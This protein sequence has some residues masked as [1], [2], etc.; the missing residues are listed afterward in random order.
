MFEDLIPELQGP[1]RDLYEASGAAGLI[2]RVTSTL[3]TAR[4]QRRLRRRWESG[5]SQFPAALPGTSAHEFGYAFDMVVA[6]FEAL[7]DV[8]YTWQ[9]WGGIWGGAGDPVHFEYPGFTRPSPEGPSEL[10]KAV[11]SALSP[12]PWW[13]GL[14]GMPSYAEILKY[15]TRLEKRAGADAAI[16]WLWGVF[17]T[18][19]P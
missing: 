1:A 8:G 14:L 5:L 3:R 2:P 11:N 13:A 16:N 4:E 6:P 10:A 18:R 7:A 17:G 19:A 9:Q 15:A 12:G